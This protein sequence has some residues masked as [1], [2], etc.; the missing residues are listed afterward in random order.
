MLAG[1]AFKA[2]LVALTL[3]TPLLGVWV[4][5]SLAAYA[6]APYWVPLAVGA[7]LLPVGPATWELWAR[8]RRRRS[9]RREIARGRTPR[10]PF[11]TTSDRLIVRTL[12]LSAAFLAVLLA[13]RPEVA[14]VALATR[15]D[16]MLDGR[17]GP[18]VDRARRTLF[19]AA[20]GLEWLYRLSHKNPF[21][22]PTPTPGPT[23]QGTLTGTPHP[24]PAP[25]PGPVISAASATAPLATSA[26][27]WPPAA[28]AAP[29]AAPTTAPTW[30]VP[31][32]VHPLVASMP[33]AID[34]NI[35]AMGA[36]FQQ[37]VAD[38]LERVKAVH[39]YVADRIAYDAE[40]YLAHRYPPQDA[41]SVLRERKGVC[42]GYAAVFRDLAQA[43]GLEAVFVGGDVRGRG[44]AAGESHA[45]NAV[46]V[47]QR[48]YLV[49]TTWDSGHLEGDRFVR[50]FRTDYLMP[51]PGVM[52]YT[53][54]PDDER[55]QLRD[56]PISRGDFLRQPQLRPGFFV[57]GLSLEQPDRPQVD[58]HDALTVR[59]RNPRHQRV[60]ID[61]HPASD[62]Q[63]G[64]IC[65]QQGSDV[66]DVTCRF[67][68]PGS[69]TVNVFAD[70]TW[71]ATVEAQ[72]R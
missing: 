27:T 32:T 16:W 6:R 25:T 4:A 41:A 11:L 45:W 69:Y 67:P 30:P 31:A 66:L 64:G 71:V 12:L 15:G 34:G 68:G 17:S 51:P 56:R 18:H 52:G 35:A 3:G 29:T 8:H 42:A 54:L 72:A 50:N 1:A 22:D 5:S 61:F 70:S 57:A 20:Q 24:G 33:P 63:G 43:A 60:Q 38:P 26:P 48:W 2:G 9:D 55:W 28:P 37:R 44:S 62:R 19:S 40:S 47:W 10:A 49:D 7:L 58:V 36:Y 53:H 23:A 65:P 14:F 21:R 39:D 59:L 46:R 13:S